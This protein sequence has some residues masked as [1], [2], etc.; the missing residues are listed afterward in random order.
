[1]LMIYVSS[2]VLFI[3]SILSAFQRFGSFSGYRG[4]NATRTLN[5][6]S[7][8]NFLPLMSKIKQD[9][10]RLGSVHLLFI[11][12]ISAVKNEHFTQIPLPF[13][14]QRI[15]S[16]Q[17]I[18]L[19]WTSYGEKRHLGSSKSTLQ[20]CSPASDNCNQCHAPSCKL[21]DMF[22]CYSLLTRFWQ[23]YVATM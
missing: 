16:K 23:N 17:L 20:K 8:V 19:F 4:I 1:M 5:T 21:T 11:R 6:L 12:I 10:Q 2:P 22:C 9:L 14:L 15:F 7:A 3:S 13:Y 18:K